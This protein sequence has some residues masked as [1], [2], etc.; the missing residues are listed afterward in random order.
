MM[1]L[2]Q[3]TKW[4]SRLKLI[5]SNFGT[6]V[7]A[8]FENFGKDFDPKSKTEDKE[9]ALR[10]KTYVGKFAYYNISLSIFEFKTFDTIIYLVS[11]GLKLLGILN[12]WKCKVTNKI[13]KLE[14]YFIHYSQKFHLLCFNMISTEVALY[15]VRTTFHQSEPL[16]FDSA[17]A[18]VL[19]LML[20]ADYIEIWMKGMNLRRQEE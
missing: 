7:D 4:Y 3:L 20:I 12:L 19:M 2:S 16:D 15:C 13:S 5:D 9:I 10:T 18:I 8:Y 1:K 6:T 17:K 11:F 14:I